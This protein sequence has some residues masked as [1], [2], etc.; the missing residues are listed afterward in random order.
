MPKCP[1]CKKEL[2]ELEPNYDSLTEEQQIDYDAGFNRPFHCPNC[3][4]DLRLDT[5]MYSTTEIDEKTIEDL[6]ERAIV[7]KCFIEV[8]SLIYVVLELY[9]KARISDKVTKIDIEKYSEFKETKEKKWESLKSRIELIYR[10]DEQGKQKGMIDYAETAYIFNLIDKTLFDEL[11]HFNK[12]RNVVIHKLLLKTKKEQKTKINIYPEI[13]DIAE[14]GRRI[15]LK[16]S[17]IGHSKTEIDKLLE[18]F[19]ITEKEAENDDFLI[20]DTKK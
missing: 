14:L 13:L 16:L 18:Q 7:K 2:D 11:K 6:I 8:I 4:K 12:M 3:K 5:G 10:V 19:K 9:L 1:K 20:A 17:Q 15:Q